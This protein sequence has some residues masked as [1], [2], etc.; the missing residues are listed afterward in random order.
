MKKWANNLFWIIVICAASISLFIIFSYSTSTQGI[1]VFRFSF[2]RIIIALLPIFSVLLGFTMLVL[3]HYHP[4]QY[5]KLLSNV[6]NIAPDKLQSIGSISFWISIFMGGFLLYYQLGILPNE[7]N[8]LPIAG[9]KFSLF[10]EYINHLWGSLIL[11]EVWMILIFGYLFSLGKFQ[12]KKQASGLFTWGVVVFTVFTTIF[13]WTVFIFELHVF[14]QI[15]GWYWPIIHKPNLFFHAFIFGL[16]LLFLIAIA[17]IYFRFPQKH[18]PYLILLSI[19]FLGLQYSIGIMEGRGLASLTDRFFL[20]YHRIYIEEACNATVSPYTA[21]S[22]YEDLYPSMF[23]QTKPPGVLWS[24][25]MVTEI[26]NAPGISVLMDK[27]SVN[28]TLSEKLPRMSSA[29]CMRSMAFV[30]LFYPFLSIATIWLIYFFYKKIVMSEAFAQH[31]IYSAFL[32]ILA[33]NIVMLSLFPD[34]AIYPAL[35]L[36]LICMLLVSMQKK[37][38]WLSFLCGVALYGALFLTFSILPVLAVPIIYYI[39]TI[40]QQNRLKEFWQYFKKTLLPMGIGLLFS[41]VLFKLC[42]HYDIFTRYRNMMATRIEGDFYTRLGIMSHGS[43]TIFEKIQQ[44]WNAAILN[45]IELAVAVGIP[46]FVF[47]VIVGIRSLIS[48]IHRDADP[49]AAINTSLFL[50]YVMLNIIR[51]VL[52]E[53]GRLWMFWVPIMAM[54]AIQLIYPFIQRNKWVF[55]G[56]LIIQMATLFISYQYQDYLMPQ[57]LP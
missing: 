38:V 4:N 52:G 53:A 8:F 1:W 11:F 19:A 50:P 18:W 24:A 10:C 43:V 55:I 36:L 17:V 25:F 31:A 9:N 2:Q 34:Q 23:L 15:P 57:L 28:L 3:F 22:K 16:L 26:A 35:F 49:I 41:M 6:N 37:S 47:F 27:V 46:V 14:E 32:F 7:E 5:E 20:S 48:V 51:V 45:N 40:W 42:L 21:I 29:R 13:Q 33:P 44:T 39:S 56:I 54:L 12:F 30:S